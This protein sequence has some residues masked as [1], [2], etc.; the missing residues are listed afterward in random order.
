MMQRRSNQQSDLGTSLVRA[1]ASV[2]GAKTETAGA[3][4][5]VGWVQVERTNSA[6][7]AAGTLDVLL[8]DQVENQ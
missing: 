2:G 5:R 1:A 6:L 4:F 8:Q 7:I 3:A